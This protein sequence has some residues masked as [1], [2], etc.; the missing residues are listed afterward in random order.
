MTDKQGAVRNIVNII[1]YAIKELE[2]FTNS[3]THDVAIERFQNNESGNETLQ[4][5]ATS[6]VPPGENQCRQCKKSYPAEQF[7]Y[8][9]TRIDSRGY[10]MRSN[11]LCRNCR[12]ASN[13]ERSAVFEDVD[14][15]PKPEK[16]AVCPRCKR[17]WAGEWHRHHTEDDGFVAWWCSN[18]NMA[19]QDQRNPNNF[20]SVD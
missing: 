15:P 13:M 18:C 16:G 12:Q 8:Y 3:K 7:G 9:Q 14:F 17:E 2:L 1:N 11:A 4:Y 19:W 20:K 5:V 6:G 10:L